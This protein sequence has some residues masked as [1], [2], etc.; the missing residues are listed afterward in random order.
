MVT[1]KLAYLV[2]LQQITCRGARL[3]LVGWATF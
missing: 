1:V 3:N 2:L